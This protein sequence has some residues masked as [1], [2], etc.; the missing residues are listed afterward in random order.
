M[1]FAF[2]NFCIGDT[3]I[4]NE[5]GDLL[6]THIWLQ[7]EGPLVLCFGVGCYR[8]WLYISG[9]DMPSH[10]LRSR[11]LQDL[12][13][14]KLKHRVKTQEAQFN[15]GLFNC[16]INNRVDCMWLVSACHLNKIFLREFL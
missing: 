4:S 10:L 15:F 14:Q 2:R 16:C 7:I 8:R 11:K 12:N 3:I 6:F 13:T 9:E 5:A 1:W